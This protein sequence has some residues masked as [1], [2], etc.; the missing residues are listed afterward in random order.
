[1]SAIG[2]FIDIVFYSYQLDFTTPGIFP[3]KAC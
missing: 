2:S 3:D 1:M